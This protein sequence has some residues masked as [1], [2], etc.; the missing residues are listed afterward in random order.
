MNQILKQEKNVVTLKLTVGSDAFES[1]CQKAYSKNKGKYNIPGFR[2]GK[3][4]RTVI[5]KMYGEGVFFEDAIDIVFPEEYKTAV[6]ELNIEVIDRPALDVEEI[7]KGKE[8]VMVVTVPVKPEVKLGEYKGLEVKQI[9]SEVTEDDIAADLNKMQEQ[10]ARLITVEDRAIIDQ[11]NITLDFCGSVDGV[12]FPGGKAENYSL[13]VGSN[14]FIP[15]FEEQLLG[16]KIGEEKEVKVTFPEEYNAEELKGKEAVFAVKINEIKE[17]QLPEI[18]DEFV[19]DTTEFDTLEE[20]KN[21][22]KTKLSVQKKRYA[23]DTMKNEVVEKLAENAEVEIPEVIVKNEIEN[24][25]KDFEHNLSQQGMD[26]KTYFQYT[27]SSKEDLEEQMKE[28]AEKR[29]KISLSVETV[30]KAEVVEATDEDLEAEYVK[31]AEL[32]K[33]ELEQIKEIFQNSQETGI[34]STI[35]ARK[36]VDFLLDNA[37]LV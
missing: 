6:E 4:T 18:D 37:K 2:K 8:L 16:M 29:V 34:K 36:T 27:G 22:I 21:D 25:M 3:A 23:E 7:G 9:E 12:E 31:M 26:L 32:Y 17:K 15:G 30:S 13:V 19:K 20:L 1:A 10:N 33:L 14:S 28:D 35:V 5:E 11:D 24:M